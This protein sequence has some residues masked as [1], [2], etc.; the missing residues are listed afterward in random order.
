V[1]SDKALRDTLGEQGFQYVTRA[2][3]LEQFVSAYIDAYQTVL[4]APTSGRE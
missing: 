4:A 2:R 1:N 3:G